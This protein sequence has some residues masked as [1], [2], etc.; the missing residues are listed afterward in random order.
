MKVLQDLRL[1]K[2]ILCYACCIFRHNG[3]EKVVFLG[4]FFIFLL[5]LIIC[6]LKVG[7]SISLSLIKQI[8]TFL[9]GYFFSN[10]WS[11][12]CCLKEHDTCIFQGLK[13]FSSYELENKVVTIL[14]QYRVLQRNR[15]N[16]IYVYILYISVYSVCL[17]SELAII[18]LSIQ[19]S[20]YPSILSISYLSIGGGWKKGRASLIYFKELCFGTVRVGKSE[21]CNVGRQARDSG[22]VSMLLSGEFFLL[23]KTSV[24]AL[25]TFN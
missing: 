21:I 13:S 12:I 19:P 18:H 23:W 4:L 3:K 16:R 24:F 1:L 6:Y 7:I 25:K 11:Y 14:G 9:N 22:R 20:I 15:I 10:K 17:F 8:T 2:N 5:D